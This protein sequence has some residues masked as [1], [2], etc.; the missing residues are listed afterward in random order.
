[1]AEEQSSAQERTEEP[2]QRRLDKS[3]KDGEV[4]RSRE[5]VTTCL[6]LGGV[7]AVLA[8]SPFIAGRFNSLFTMNL[9][10]RVEALRDA[11]HLPAHLGESVLMG[12]GAFLPVFAVI[13]FSVLVGS[14]I[15]GGWVFSS[16]QFAPKFN[17]LS[18]LQGLKRMFSV[19]SL[20]ELVKSILKVSLIVGALVF[21]ITY[22]WPE[23]LSLS[24]Q[25]TKPALM[26]SLMLAGTGILSYALGLAL[27]AAIDIPFQKWQHIKK[28][29]M[30]KQELK[31]ENK[32]TEG[33]P[34]LKSRIKDM[35]REQANRR[36]MQEVPKADVV[37]R[38][39]SHY[40][41]ALK[42]DTNRARAPFVIAK[43]AD[44]IAV[45]IIQIADEHQRPVVRSP[46][47]T[48]A[49][50]YSTKLNQEVAADLYMAIAQVLAYVYRLRQYK[51]GMG[52]QPTPLP[53]EFEIPKHLR[54]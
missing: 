22:Q 26:H 13:L 43:G 28:L 19:R 54:H 9:N 36:M 41:V 25:G 11:S 29:R 4:A 48:R 40:A 23:L 32:E 33:S 7:C 21:V 42:Y 49:I 47:L 27:I 6:F 14:L 30:T 8:F 37:I 53:D 38:N 3:R 10:L 18:P 20:V 34:E 2:S 17:R 51:Q 50:Y 52:P 12:I 35:Q 1:M 16:K 15:M 31:D 45:K 44:E 46:A 24:K 39:P 5:L